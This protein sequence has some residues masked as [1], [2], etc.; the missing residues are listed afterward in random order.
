MMSNLSLGRNRKLSRD[1]TLSELGVHARGASEE[2]KDELFDLMKETAHLLCGIVRGTMREEIEGILKEEY[3][4]SEGDASTIAEEV[5]AAHT[6]SGLPKKK[7]GAAFAFGKARTSCQANGKFSV[8]SAFSSKTA[9]SS[10]ADKAAP[11]QFMSSLPPTESSGTFGGP[12]K[13]PPS[14]G[15]AMQGPGPML[16]TGLSTAGPFSSGISLALPVS[17]EPSLSVPSMAP[18]GFPAPGFQSSSFGVPLLM[19]PFNPSNES[20]P[21]IGTPARLIEDGEK[22]QKEGDKKGK[23]K[24][25]KH[26]KKSKSNSDSDSDSDSDEESDDS[27]ASED[28]SDSDESGNDESGSDSSSSS[29]EGGKGK[30]GYKEN[31]KPVKG[32]MRGPLHFL[33]EETMGYNSSFDT[34]IQLLQKERLIRVNRQLPDPVCLGNPFNKG[35]WRI[36]MSVEDVNPS[37]HGFAILQVRESDMKNAIKKRDSSLKPKKSKSKSTSHQ[38]V[39]PFA[40]PFCLASSSAFLSSGPIGEYGPFGQ[41]KWKGVNTEGMVINDQE[42][43]YSSLPCFN[44]WRSKGSQIACEVNTKKKTATF[45][46][47]RKKQAV[48]FT[49]LPK[50]VQFQMI[51]HA[52]ALS[53]KVLRLDKIKK[54]TGP[55]KVS[56][57]K[58][59]EF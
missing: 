4:M 32:K 11:K 14:F 43:F 31:K 7:G 50:C 27:E 23:K 42:R 13:F 35:I 30:E 52:S 41:G 25:R 29:S 44:P 39:N 6:S 47:D 20:S 1:E 15:S 16:P 54:P 40:P 48:V 26:E 55:K 46:V 58:I 9:S 5:I 57:T 24:E 33:P 34:D 53:M 37:Y 28:E 12:S 22:W 49:K 17:D 36:D 19:P 21:F 3:G 51:F 10:S 38:A 59:F 56:G 2:K 8:P 18:P 45:F